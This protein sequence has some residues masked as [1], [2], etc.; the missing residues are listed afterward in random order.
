MTDF[1]VHTF[2]LFVKSTVLANLP[3]PSVARYLES[4]SQHMSEAKKANE[5]RMYECLKEIYFLSAECLPLR[6]EEEIRQKV[7]FYLYDLR[8][9][10]WRKE[11]WVALADSYD[12]LLQVSSQS[13]IRFNA[14]L[15]QSKDA[16]ILLCNCLQAY[17]AVLAVSTDDAATTQDARK[18]LGVMLYLLIQG[19]RKLENPYPGDWYRQVCARA[20]GLFK[21]AH[22]PE[23][24]TIEYYQGKLARK[25]ALSQTSEHADECVR[26]HK[27][28]LEHFYVSAVQNVEEET[29][30]LCIESLY[31]LHS[32]RAKLI[33][34][35]DCSNEMRELLDSYSLTR[36]VERAKKENG[37]TL[38]DK[39]NLNVTKGISKSDCAVTLLSKAEKE[40]SDFETAVQL[41]AEDGVV[42]Q[43][44]AEGGDSKSLHVLRDC[45]LAMRIAIKKNSKFWSSKTRFRLAWMIEQSSFKYLNLKEDEVQTAVSKSVNEL[46]QPLFFSEKDAMLPRDAIE[47]KF[48][49][50]IENSPDFNVASF[51]N[52][53]M[54]MRNKTK[55][56]KLFVTHLC[57]LRNDETLG[58]LER[59][60]KLLGFL[61]KEEKVRCSNKEDANPHSFK[62]AIHHTVKC[63]FGAMQ[64]KLLGQHRK[65]NENCKCDHSKYPLQISQDCPI[66]VQGKSQDSAEFEF[67]FWTA[68]KLRNLLQDH[69][70]LFNYL[71][72]DVDARLRRDLAW[73]GQLQTPPEEKI[74]L[75]NRACPLIN[76]LHSACTAYCHN[77]GVIY[78]ET[79]QNDDGQKCMGCAMARWKEA[80]DQKKTSLQVRGEE[81]KAVVSAST[82]LEVTE[83]I[84]APLAGTEVDD[85]ADDG[86]AAIVIE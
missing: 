71:K 73:Q 47:G 6:N 66:L 15:G 76:L 84:D 12:E 68:G 43:D 37:G 14:L 39:G 79:A 53:N 4:V 69:M 34:S 1:R 55:L 62:V 74:T 8:I 23:D 30:T 38:P 40:Q 29:S 31:K 81:P 17:S 35:T 50:Y 41:R 18:R 45:M 2:T 16:Q 75:R 26:R 10:P 20:Y 3:V 70:D 77:K 9:N 7:D 72:V 56:I 64:N 21:E 5:R 61:I 83:S 19:T 36:C 42:R 25:L 86:G 78:F 11:S 85:G 67:V 49:N 13:G 63:L 48:S 57:S 82:T 65:D 51:N 80:F 27:E 52:L 24:W 44:A 32:T 59:V 54:F 58:A 33:L 46:L 22:D 28:S 60:G